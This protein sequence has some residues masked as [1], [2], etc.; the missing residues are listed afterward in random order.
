LEI[1]LIKSCSYNQHEILKNILSLCNLDKFDADL[2]FG[3]GSFYKDIPEPDYKFDI[4]P[5]AKQHNNVILA[6]SANIPLETKSLKSL[7]FD[8]PFMTYVK[9]GRTGNGNMIMAKRFGGYWR[10]DELE[11][12]YKNT[13][14]E[15]HRLLIEKGVMVFK[16]Q[17]IVHN[18]KL[19]P[20]HIFIHE[21]IENLFRLK[22]LF[23]LTAKNRMAIPQTKGTATKVQKHARVHHS[24]FLVLERL[25]D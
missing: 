15:A 12:H 5:N 20:T 7:V 4:D 14:I 3:N 25:K 11:E 17:D 21:W 23:V 1:K 13:I 24:Y 22:D 6:D 9:S 10:Y 2:T 16:C 18:H 19:H 8:P